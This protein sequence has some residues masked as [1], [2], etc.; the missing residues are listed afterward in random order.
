[1]EKS[2]VII[3]SENRL[4]EQATTLVLLAKCNVALVKHLNATNTQKIEAFK[5]AISKLENAKTLYQKLECM[6]KVKDV[7]YL[8]VN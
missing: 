8:Q 1:M 7:V 3:F 5:S 4:C 6:A 2:S